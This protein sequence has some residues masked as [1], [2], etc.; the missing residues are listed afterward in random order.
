[1]NI[2][3]IIYQIFAA[4]INHETHAPESETNSNFFK[5]YINPLRELNKKRI[6]AV[7]L[8]ILLDTK[9]SKFNENHKN[10]LG[11][12]EESKSLEEIKKHFEELNDVSAESEVFVIN[13]LKDK[14]TNILDGILNE[15]YKEFKVCMDALFLVHNN[16][17][18]E[19]RRKFLKD[20]DDLNSRFSSD[21][22]YVIQEFGRQT[23]DYA[24]FGDY[25]N[26][27]DN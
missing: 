14:M 13:Q 24:S 4:E 22:E 20:I 10:G 5:Q 11:A 12:E 3:F 15:T 19:L 1:M 26:P 21:S 17:V 18:E 6:E 16:S 27:V 23:K 7:K 25:L 8:F 2:L 9:I